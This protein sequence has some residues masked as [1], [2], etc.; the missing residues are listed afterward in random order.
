M[1]VLPFR[2]A[3]RLL[4]IFAP[5]FIAAAALAIGRAFRK[6]L[7]RFLEPDDT[8]RFYIAQALLYGGTFIAVAV[9]MF[10]RLKR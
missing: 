9:S 2:A 5:F 10:M 6:V 1:T 4:A 3:P 8:R 7:D